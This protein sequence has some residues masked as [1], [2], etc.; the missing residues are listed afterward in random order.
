MPQCG[1]N[2][3]GAKRHRHPVFA[4]FHDGVLRR[5]PRKFRHEN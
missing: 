5:N 1:T 3:N 4:F 2:Q